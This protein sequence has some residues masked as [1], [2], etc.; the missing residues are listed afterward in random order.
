MKKKTK[1]VEYR[2]GTWVV[3]VRGLEPGSG[4]AELK[5][6][7]TP[8][9]KRV[10][11]S[12]TKGGINMKKY[13]AGTWSYFKLHW[14]TLL[15]AILLGTSLAFNVANYVIIDKYQEVT[16]ELVLTNNE[17]AEDLSRYKGGYYIICNTLKIEEPEKVLELILEYEKIKNLIK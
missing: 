2:N 12:Q 5:D 3:N 7:K 11:T 6:T 16:A 4:V 9:V 10:N 1:W 8:K 13:L 15:V 14:A 17:L